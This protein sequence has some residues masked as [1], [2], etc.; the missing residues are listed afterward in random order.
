MEKIRKKKKRKEI[1]IK[2]VRVHVFYMTNLKLFYPVLKYILKKNL[3]LRKITNV[4]RI[5]IKI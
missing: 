4:L 2:I 5:S 3:L 1:I